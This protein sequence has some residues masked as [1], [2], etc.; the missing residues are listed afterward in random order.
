M[1]TIVIPDVHHRIKNVQNILDVETDYDEV[2]FLGD[3]FDSFHEPPIV[4]SFEDTGL[5]LKHLITEHPNK[6]KF[7]FL[8]GN[9]DIQ[10]IYCNNN[11]SHTSIHSPAS[12]YCSGFSKNKAKTFRKVFFDNN[13]KDQFFIDNFRL[14]YKTQNW[15]LSHAG[16]H[17][18]HIPYNKD[19]DFIINVAAKEAWKNFRNISH[20]HNWIISAVGL[21]RGGCDRVGGAL[22][23]D[24]RYEFQPE[25][26][27]GKQIVGHTT[28]SA[29]SVLGQGTDIES[30]N[31]DTTKHYCVIDNGVV[32]PKDIP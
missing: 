13:L 2:V 30:W 3:W 16:L 11:S 6:S 4:A 31:F 12:Y 24:W 20:Q 23:L 7:I 15:T 5:Y 27:L 18:S 10:Y 22:W 8:L 25:I 28:I 26:V 17:A 19:I 29:P 1:K 21:C 9:H 32:V 14:V